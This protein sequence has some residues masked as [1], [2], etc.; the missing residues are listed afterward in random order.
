MRGEERASGRFDTVSCL[1]EE[2]A[3]GEVR[4]RFSMG[5]LAILEEGNEVK[6]L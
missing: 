5:V 1:G 4:W 3:C 6:F 2:R